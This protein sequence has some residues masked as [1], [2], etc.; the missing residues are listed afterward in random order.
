MEVFNF[1][2]LLTRAAV[3]LRGGSGRPC[4]RVIEPNPDNALRRVEQSA[5][6]KRQGAGAIR[7]PRIASHDALRVA[8]EGSLGAGERIAGPLVVRRAGSTA[9]RRES[10]AQTNAVEGLANARAT[11]PGGSEGSVEQSRD[12]MDKNRMISSRM[13]CAG[14][15]VMLVACEAVRAAN[16]G[17]IWCGRWQQARAQ[18]TTA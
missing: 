11:L 1:C 16:S 17:G 15:F 4:L 8:F 10:S 18:A 14:S 2:I 6:S 7:E 9:W 13:N 3:T 5:C 12:P